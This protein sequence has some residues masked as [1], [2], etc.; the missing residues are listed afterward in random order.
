MPAPELFLAHAGADTAATEQL[1]DLL[2]PAV[3]A[4]LDSRS[5]LPGDEWPVEIP[6]AQR[7]ALATVILVSRSADRA[8]Y[9]RDEIHTAIALHRKYPGEHRAVAVFLDGRPANPMAVPYGLRVL[10]SLDAVAEGGLPGVARKPCELV[11]ALRARG[12]LGPPTPLP[13][14]PMPAAPTPAASP[15]PLTGQALYDLLYRLTL[16][17]QL[18]A[19][20]LRADLPREHIR[21][22][23]APIAQRAIDIV[24][25]VDGG[26][27]EL[28]ACVA[29]AIAKEAPYLVGTAPAAPIAQASD[30]RFRVLLVLSNPKGTSP[31]R[32]QAEERALRESIQLSERRD[33]F[34]VETLPAA[35]V[36]STESS[37]P[38]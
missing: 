29:R 30:E 21:P 27:P 9:L 5:L 15:A 3:T 16:G 35:T 33:S 37:C 20:I 1:F 12:A 22:S 25:I 13:P 28:A 26:G 36:F 2:A 7:A 14:A 10:H 8:Y 38:G 4:W 6:R 24:Q 17:A 32:L 34:D 11:A 18:D 19:V 23:S 31:L